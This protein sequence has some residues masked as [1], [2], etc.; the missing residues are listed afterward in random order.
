MDFNFFFKDPKSDPASTKENISDIFHQYDIRGKYPDQINENIFS[1][2]AS[3]IVSVLE[4]KRI[5]LGRDSRNSSPALSRA[6]S[7]GFRSQGINVLDVGMITTPFA[8]WLSIKKNIDVLMVTASHNPADQ[9]GLK[10]YSRLKGAVSQRN[11]LK[12][13]EQ[14]LEA[15]IKDKS[16]EPSGVKKKGS[17]Q[18]KDFKEEYQKQI[19]KIIGRLNANSLRLALDYSNGT[20]GLI[21]NSIF[22]RLKIRFTTINEEPN[23]DFP[24]HVPNPLKSETHQKLKWLLKKGRYNLGA[25]FDGDGDRIAFFD[26]KGDL[27]L[28]AQVFALLADFYLPLSPRFKSVVVTASFS[29]IIKDVVAEYQGQVYVSAVGRT[30]VGPLMKNK[31]SLMGAERSG[32][33]FFKEFNYSDNGILALL[34][35]LKILAVKKK[36]LSKLIAPFKK[37]ITLPEIDLPL[38]KGTEKEILRAV[39][40]TFPGGRIS[41]IDGLTV[42]YKDWWFNLRPSNTQVIWRLSLEGE[43]RELLEE[44]RTR[45]EEI[46]R[47]FESSK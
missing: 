41:R 28:P 27:I 18:K 9:N 21:A 14:K 35:L 1:S 37:Y 23:G 44:K 25:I 11:G 4:P 30:N 42:E 46:I 12:E 31:R 33:Y 20:S 39:R 32:H 22:E 3:A 10:I 6:L 24:G 36:P 38:Q 7:E 43:N 8:A 5:I 47:S 19:L 2:L 26:E 40:E 29:K 16:P 45:L 13:I 17:W 15:I 34:K